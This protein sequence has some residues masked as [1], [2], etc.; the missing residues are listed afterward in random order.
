M[1][2]R[3]TEPQSDG[4][5]GGNEGEWAVVSQRSLL[6]PPIAAVSRVAMLSG[7]SQAD[8]ADAAWILRGVATNDRH[9][10]R[11]EK[12]SLVEKQA[13]MGRPEATRAAL[14]LLRKGQNGG[15]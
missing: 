12:R 15:R 14:I 4:F 1:T 5:I 7:N 3:R 6:G 10:T 11:D 2:D 8:A 9:T 13:P